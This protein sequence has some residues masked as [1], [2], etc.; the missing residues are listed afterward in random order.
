MSV[1]VLGAGIQALAGLKFS[2][3]GADFPTIR[4]K[5]PK[6]SM[7]C[8]KSPAEETCPLESGMIHVNHQPDCLYSSAVESP[9]QA[10]CHLQGQG[11]PLPS[12]VCHPG[13]VTSPCLLLSHCFFK[14]IMLCAVFVPLESLFCLS[15]LETRAG[16]LLCTLLFSAGLGTLSSI[17]ARAG[18][19][20]FRFLL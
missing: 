10:P 17:P 7:I 1:W 8:R 18:T 16:C 12:H 5:P 13:Q 4:R 3:V 9:S 11:L 14:H 6:V 19:V 2:L 15:T 20:L